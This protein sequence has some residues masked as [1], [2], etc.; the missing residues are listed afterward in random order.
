MPAKLEKP[1]FGY[2][3]PQDN[4]R[5]FRST[6]KANTGVVEGKVGDRRSVTVERNYNR[7]GS[8][9]PYPDTAVFVSKCKR[10]LV[11]IPRP[12]RQKD[13]PNCENILVGLALGDGRD[14]RATRRISP[15]SQQFALLHV[16]AKHLLAR[17][18]KYSPCARSTCSTSDLIVSRPNRI[19]RSGRDEP[20]R[21]RMLKLPRNQ[22]ESESA[23][24]P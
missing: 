19:G 12:R 21:V 5:I 11:Q 6:R 18:R 23:L 16:P 14:L 15:S 13:L 8:R 17:A 7:L 10:A 2:Q 1:D 9:I 22:L 4:V 24:R 20:K 3:I